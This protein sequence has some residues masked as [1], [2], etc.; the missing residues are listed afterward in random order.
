MTKKQTTLVFL[1][2]ATLANIVLIL[3]LLILFTIGGGFLF[4]EKL[5]TALPFLFIAALVAGILIYQKAVKFIVK[6]F[7]L[8][9]KMDPLFRPR[10]RRSPLD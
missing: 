10:G 5:G 9:E 4:K 3:A 8:E 1:L 7:N 2:V 6:K